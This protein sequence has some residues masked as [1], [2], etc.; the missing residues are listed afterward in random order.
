MEQEA[1]SNYQFQSPDLGSSL[2]DLEEKHSLLRDRILLISQT[3]IQEREKTFSDILELK[4]TLSI[5]R[6]ET[7]KIKEFLQRVSEQLENTTRK[8]ELSILQR[9][10]DLFRQK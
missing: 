1:Y 3:L 5:L 6:E 7:T 2:R 10:F 8:E 9:Q 4:K